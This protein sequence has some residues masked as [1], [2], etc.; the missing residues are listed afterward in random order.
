MWCI[1]AKILQELKR[2]E[3][4]NFIKSSAQT[5]SPRAS[6]GEL[7]FITKFT[8]LSLFNTKYLLE[9]WKSNNCSPQKKILKIEQ[10]LIRHY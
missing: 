10:A 7:Q 2:S 6:F 4:E 3:S 9:E 8:K 5:N 1:K